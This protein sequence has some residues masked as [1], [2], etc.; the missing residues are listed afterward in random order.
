MLEGIINFDRMGG[1]RLLRF[2]LDHIG[3]TL[4]SCSS[5]LVKTIMSSRPGVNRGPDAAACKLFDSEDMPPGSVGTPSVDLNPGM[6]S[7]GGGLS[8]ELTS[9]CLDASDS[10][11]LGGVDVSMPSAS[12]GMPSGSVDLSSDSEDMPSVTLFGKGTDMPSV[13]GEISGNLPSSGDVE[14]IELNVDVKGGGVSLGAG[15]AAGA[16]AA[17]GAV[18]VG[19]GLLGEA[20]TSDG[21]VRACVQFAFTE[22]EVWSL[23]GCRL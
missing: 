21:K 1:I 7:A 2:K 8:G 6:P 18:E 16:T 22:A 12:L 10:L 13:G 20:D 23:D 9:A 3:S 11:P 4:L 17:A 15:M 19:V 14:L 5:T